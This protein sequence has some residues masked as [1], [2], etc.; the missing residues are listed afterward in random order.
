M[1]LGHIVFF[2]EYYFP[3]I[4]CNSLSSHNLQKL[5]VILLPLTYLLKINAGGLDRWSNSIPTFSFSFV[6][7]KK[8]HPNHHHTRP[9]TSVYMYDHSH[10]HS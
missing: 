6:E 10:M 9:N 3:K 1:T 7:G 5:L 8:L 4:D 2:L